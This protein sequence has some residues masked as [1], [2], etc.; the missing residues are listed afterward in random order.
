MTFVE[1]TFEVFILDELSQITCESDH[2]SFDVKVRISHPSFAERESM[3]VSLLFKDMIILGIKVKSWP[4][5]IIPNPYDNNTINIAKHY[6]E[7]KKYV[8]KKI[9]NA[10]DSSIIEKIVIN[11]AREQIKAALRPNYKM[12]GSKMFREI[13]TEIVDLLDVEQVIKS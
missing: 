11:R 8:E 9:L 1:P 7:Y 6:V 5:I 3:I 13:V 2:C 10:I 12:L 4:P